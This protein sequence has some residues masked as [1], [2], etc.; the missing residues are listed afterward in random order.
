MVPFNDLSRGLDTDRAALGEAVQ[1]VL[2][3][4]W[5][6]LGPETDGFEHEL[7]AAFGAAGAVGVGSGT[8]ALELAMRA[9]GCSGGGEVVMAANAG[10]Y[11]ALACLAAGGIPVFADVRPGSV[12]IDPASVA[13]LVTDTTCAVVVTHLYGLAT[14]VDEVRAAAPGIPIIEDGSQAHGARVGAACVGA[15]GDLAAFSFYPTKNLAA[16]GDGGAVTG[17][18]ADLL[19]R[20]RRLRQYG[21]SERYVAS[22]VGGRNSRLDE[23][24]AAV[25]RVRLRSLDATNGARVAIAERLRTGCG[26]LVPFVHADHSSS[27]G[28]YV[29]HLCVLRHPQ[30]D[31]IRSQ[32]AE[33]GVSTAIHFPVPDHRQPGIATSSHRA[34]D[35]AHTDEV[36]AEVLSLPCFPELTDAEVDHVVAA[37]RAVV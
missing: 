36:C 10:G 2:D 31:R 15:L 4:G 24:Q 12:A 26:D 16:L 8:D 23:L 27:A 30:R 5:F 9:T 35:L 32:L 29:G 33:R 17:T 21:W 18:D 7:A 37:V 3:S 34:G 22:D 13:S 28:G 11:A 6:V 14:D 19:A 25:L 20:V 1:R